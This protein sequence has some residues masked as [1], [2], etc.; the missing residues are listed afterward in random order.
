MAEQP[1]I[2]SALTVCTF[3]LGSDWFGVD[4]RLVERVTQ[5]PARTPVPLAPDVVWGCVN[6]RGQIHL[7]V[8][9]RSRLGANSAPAPEGQPALI[10]LRPA[11]GERLGIVADRI[12]RIVNVTPA[13]LDGAVCG[14]L[15][16]DEGDRQAALALGVARLEEG[17]LTLLD[18]KQIPRLLDSPSAAAANS[19]TDNT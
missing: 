3:W 2:D 10:V 17:L 9:L 4:A 5:A 14:A 13:E 6:L 15:A 18:P 19:S 7:I 16:R 11:V 12:G 8:D 1:P